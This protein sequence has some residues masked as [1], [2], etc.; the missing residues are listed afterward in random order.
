[1]RFIKHWTKHGVNRTIPIMFRLISLPNS[2]SIHLISHRKS[3]T[4]FNDLFLK[5]FFDFSQTLTRLIYT[6]DSDALL[7]TP[8]FIDLPNLYMNIPYKQYTIYLENTKFNST[9]LSVVNQALRQSWAKGNSY[10]FQAKDLSIPSIH[11]IS[12]E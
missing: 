3:T 5:F 12:S 4:L 8:D 2:F 1:M 11:P 7:S 6:I 9:I 10:F